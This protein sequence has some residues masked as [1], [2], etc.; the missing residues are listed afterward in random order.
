MAIKP[1]ELT[2][3]CADFADGVERLIDRHVSNTRLKK[4][5]LDYHGGGAD[6]S[7]H[8]EIR[9]AVEGELRSRYRNAGWSAAEITLRYKENAGRPD[10]TERYTQVSF[11]LIEIGARP[12]TSFDRK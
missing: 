6:L 11:E 7:R 1:Q 2:V 5:S 4:A 12:A 3:N 9:K 10:E 8:E